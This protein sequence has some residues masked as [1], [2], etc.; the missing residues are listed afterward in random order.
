MPYCIR[1]FILL[2]PIYFSNFI[3]IQLKKIAGYL[4]IRGDI[5][6]YVNVEK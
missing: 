4:S 3:E 2:K 6:M 1:I 5:L